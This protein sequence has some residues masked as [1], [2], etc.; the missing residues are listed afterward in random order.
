MCNG[1]L[2]FPVREG[3]TIVSFA[4]DLAVVFIG[5]HPEAVEFYATET[6]KSWLER[7]GLTLSNEKMKTILATNRKK[8][9]C[10]SESRWIYNAVKGGYQI[11]GSN[12]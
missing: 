6:V 10:E 12:N 1:V 7:A 3:T 11:P 2:G 9:H 4:D 8:N 5:K